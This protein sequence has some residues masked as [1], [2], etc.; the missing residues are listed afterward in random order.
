MEPSL[1][2]IAE[3]C[4]TDASALQYAQEL[5]LVSEINQNGADQV[6]SLTPNC[7]GR[8][9]E[10]TVEGRPRIRCNRCKKSEAFSTHLTLSE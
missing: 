2:Q 5:G 7:A 3:R 9:Y 4:K 6:C 10:T 8:L 1:L